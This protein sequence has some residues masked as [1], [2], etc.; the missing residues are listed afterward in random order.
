MEQDG[1]KK[2]DPAPEENDKREWVTLCDDL[3]RGLYAY[4]LEELTPLQQNTL[5]PFCEGK[6]FI[7]RAFSGR[8]K[9]TATLIG[10]IQRIA[11]QGLDSTQALLIVPT[12]EHAWSLARMTQELGKYVGILAHAL[13]G[14]IRVREQFTTLREQEIHVVVATA[15]RLYDMIMRGAL[16]PER[17]RMLVLDEADELMS[18]GFEDLVRD[19]TKALP[20]DVQLGMVTATM[21]PECTAFANDFMKQPVFVDMKSLAGV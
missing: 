5:V 14:G 12:R 4:G 8:G 2:E 7:V 16:D 13:V 19:V 1:L 9:T 18:R 10:M 15:G 3:A 21:S 20:H 11:S 6:D 17:V